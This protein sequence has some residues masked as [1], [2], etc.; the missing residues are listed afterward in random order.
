MFDYQRPP[1]GTRHNNGICSAGF[2]KVQSGGKMIINASQPI[3]IRALDKAY[4]PPTMKWDSES[5][6][7]NG[8]MVISSIGKINQLLII[9]RSWEAILPCYE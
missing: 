5:K 4:G 1:E 2:D 7:V 9:R 3:I 8:G 6:T